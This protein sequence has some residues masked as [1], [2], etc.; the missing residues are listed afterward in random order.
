MTDWPPPG[1]AS[2]TSRPGSEPKKL[3]SERVVLVKS[4][5]SADV[6]RTAVSMG[7]HAFDP[8]VPV[9]GRGR[10]HLRLYPAV[11]HL[12]EPRVRRTR[13]R[14]FPD[15]LRHQRILSRRQLLPI[16]YPQFAMRRRLVHPL[17]VIREP[18]LDGIDNSLAVTRWRRK[19]GGGAD[20]AS[21][22]W[23][24]LKLCENRTTP[25]GND[26]TGTYSQCAGPVFLTG[27]AAFCSTV[28]ALMKDSPSSTTYLI[29]HVTYATPSNCRVC[30]ERREQCPL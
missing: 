30:K 3:R 23:M 29:N 11:R 19:T 4:N 7:F 2:D 27:H 21:S 15:P 5:P 13:T 22:K 12:P 26:A 28:T 24:K 8:V 6:P 20:A 17:A 14:K 1:V 16:G 9:R 10:G 25:K 18:A